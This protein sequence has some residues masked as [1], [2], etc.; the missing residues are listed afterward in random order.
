MI[1]NKPRKKDPKGKRRGILI[2]RKGGRLW[3][4]I[5]VISATFTKIEIGSRGVIYAA[6]HNEGLKGMPQREFL[7]K[8]KELDKKTK[9]T[10]RNEI[11]KVFGK[12]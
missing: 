5:G 6:R 12:R 2:G 1:L 11:R 3:K 4:S 9:D 8:S 7:G 10:I